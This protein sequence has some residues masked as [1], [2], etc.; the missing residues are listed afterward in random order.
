MS[1]I[2]RVIET[3]APL[4]V[5]QDD[6]RVMIAEWYYTGNAY[7]LDA[8]IET[9]ELCSHPDIRYQFEIANEET[10]NELLVG[11][12]CIKRFRISALD[13]RGGRL[14]EHESRQ[15]VD[16]DRTKL[17]A[18]SKQRRVINALVA[19]SMDDDEFN[20]DSFIKYYREREAFTPN[21]LKVVIWRLNE[22]EIDYRP[23]DFKM[24]M[25]RNRERGQFRRLE[26]WQVK[27]IWPCLSSSQRKWYIEK[28][29]DP[30]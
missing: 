20:I 17:I 16:R 21:Q 2:N 8:P 27:K 14:N 13:D 15:K 1:W 9:C 25:S 22:H 23:S 29:G 26:G 10:E 18:D 19:L 30:T 4:S 3:L 5:E 24:I 7:D 12:E 11:S 6:A 28:V